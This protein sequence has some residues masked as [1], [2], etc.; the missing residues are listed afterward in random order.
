VKESR[1]GTGAPVA[2]SPKART[3]SARLRPADALTAV[4]AQALTLHRLLDVAA[5]HETDEVRVLVEG[6]IAGLQGLGAGS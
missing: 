1:Q 2:S 5:M 6:V 3:A 4:L